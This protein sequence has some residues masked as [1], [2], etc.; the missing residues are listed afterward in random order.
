LAPIVRLYQK[1]LKNPELVA[2]AIPQAESYIQQFLEHPAPPSYMEHNKKRLK[3]ISSW[4][5]ILLQLYRDLYGLASDLVKRPPREL[6]KTSEWDLLLH[7]LRRAF[8]MKKLARRNPFRTVE[9]VPK[10]PYAYFPLHVNP[11][12]STMIL[13]PMHV[14]QI[15]IIESI[16][17]SIPLSWNLLVKEH[18]PMIGLR[19]DGFYEQ[20]QKMPGVYLIHP[21]ENNFNLI[22]G[23]HLTCTITGTAGW[24]SLVL[25]R[26]A[27]VF[28]NAPYL[29]LE[30][31]LVH[32]PDLSQL[33][34][35]IQEAISIPPIDDQRL[36]LYLAAIYKLAF[37]F[38]SHLLWGS[39]SRETVEANWSIVENISQQIMEEHPE[40][41]ISA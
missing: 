12:A 3:Q 19:P 16:S 7:N 37:E 6:E 29:A 2:G 41:S 33:P 32:S 27:I 35:K 15:H 24:E 25:K 38:P 17:K 13:S 21:W 23:A 31:G 4:R 26:P 14:N 39:A 18:F 5:G 8:R 36:I 34:Y 30:Q 11:E 40:D 10:R 1:A 20:I 22:K 9:Q 28:G